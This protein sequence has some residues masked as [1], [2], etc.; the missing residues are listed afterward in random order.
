VPSVV[1]SLAE[2]LGIEILPIRS[3]T[4]RRPDLGVEPDAAYYVRNEPLVRGR[5]QID[6]A[7]DP[8]PDLV[9]EVD[10]TSDSI[11]K[12]PLFAALGFPEVWR[13]KEG[14]VQ[15]LRLFEVAGNSP[16]SVLIREIRSQ[17][18]TLR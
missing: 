9:I 11:E 18:A 14:K 3:T 13:Y 4:I 16:R 5:K 8:P 1:S 15:I 2:A 17:A 10:I 12:L 6:F 7:T